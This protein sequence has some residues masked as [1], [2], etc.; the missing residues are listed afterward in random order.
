MARRL[1]DV[2]CSPGPEMRRKCLHC[3]APRTAPVMPT[4]STHL[5]L[6]HTTY[7]KYTQLSRSQ[8]GARRAARGA[9][10]ANTS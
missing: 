7:S 2:I 6:P 4:R 1:V 10:A 5:R 9:S 8:V 3:T